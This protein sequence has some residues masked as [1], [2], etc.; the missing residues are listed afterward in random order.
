MS[1]ISK[2]AL[3]FLESKTGIT[4][5][6]DG[7]NYILHRPTHLGDELLS[8]DELKEAYPFI[9][10]GTTKYSSLYPVV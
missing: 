10:D 7:E 3:F 1:M 6:Q 5:E 2:Y 9:Y 8:G 4:P